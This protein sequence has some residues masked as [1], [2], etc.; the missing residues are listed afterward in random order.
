MPIVC[1]DE[2][3]VRAQVSVRTAG[4][5][6]RHRFLC[7]AQLPQDSQDVA[8]H[9]LGG[10]PV[11]LVRNAAERRL[12]PGRDRLPVAVAALAGAQTGPVHQVGGSLVRPEEEDLLLPPGDGFPVPGHQ[13]VQEGVHV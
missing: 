7:D 3:L 2:D 12:F 8:V 13:Q 1:R 9:P 10:H 4:L 6:L 5:E 11:F